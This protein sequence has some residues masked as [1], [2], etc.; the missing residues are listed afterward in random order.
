[1][2]L[3][4]F[5]SKSKKGV[6]PESDQQLKRPPRVNI[7]Q[8]HGIYFDLVEPI[9][10]GALKITNISSTGI[11]FTRDSLEQWPAAGSIIKGHLYILDQ[12]IAAAL[13]IVHIS[14]EIAGCSIHGSTRP[15][16]AILARYFDVELAAINLSQVAP[17]YLK[18]PAK[19]TANWF[20]GA[21]NCELYMVVDQ[22]SIISFN[23]TFFGNYIEW[24]GKEI[25]FG[26]IY[27]N[28]LSD[29]PT[30]KSSELINPLRSIPEEISLGAIKFINNI[31]ELKQKQR[32]CLKNILERHSK[33]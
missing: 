28:P 12:E 17:K 6:E 13:K 10:G 2:G 18:K 30:F 5:F 25:S 27:G 22:D 26:M 23:I 7:L 1:M 24:D 15:I 14:P 21:D 4:N 8:L 32:E 31:K 11:G 16:S 33:I 29:G 9:K 20:R 3:F 19:G